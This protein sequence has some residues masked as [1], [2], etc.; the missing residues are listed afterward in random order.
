MPEVAEQE[1]LE[2]RKSSK[3]TYGTVLLVI[4]QNSPMF[5]RLQ[6]RKELM[7]E[8]CWRASFAYD[9]KRVLVPL[10]LRVNGWFLNFAAPR[11]GVGLDDLLELTK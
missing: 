4:V 6:V 5:L 9:Y 1:V 2:K 8:V 10:Q 3:S 7:K 11:S